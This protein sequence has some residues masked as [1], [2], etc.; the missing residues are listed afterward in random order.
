[1]ARLA[2]RQRPTH[3]G[4]AATTLP[5][6]RPLSNNRYGSAMPQSMSQSS[7]PTLEITLNALS[8][9]LDKAEAF[10]TAKKIDPAVL[11]RT[12]LAPDMFDLT[13]QVQIATD[14]ARRGAARLAG[15]EPPSAPDNETTIAQLKER[16]A[17][18]VAFVKG[19]DRKAVDASAEHE[20]TFPLGPEKKG[21]MKGDDYL[22]HFVLPNVYFHLTAA[23]AILRHSGVE[24]G[25][26]DYLGAIPMKMI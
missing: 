7:L 16:I 11:L 19:L 24:I 2:A 1:V 22:N 4:C 18:T 14:Q 12:R 6:F 17:K 25:K 20:I 15:V 26:N 9:V 10:A 23:Y 13:R 21:H 5:A 3:I 8:A